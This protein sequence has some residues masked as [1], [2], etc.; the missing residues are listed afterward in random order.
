MGNRPELESIKDRR[1][2]LSSVLMASE[3]TSCRVS[4]CPNKTSDRK[5]FCLEHLDRMP[6][7]QVLVSQDPELSLGALPRFRVTG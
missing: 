4:T 1:L 3:R 7:V 2:A 6:Y 5:P